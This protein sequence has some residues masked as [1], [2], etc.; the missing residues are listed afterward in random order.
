[1]LVV[2]VPSTGHPWVLLISVPSTGCPWV[3]V[4]SVTS[5]GH[6]C[7]LAASNAVSHPSCAALLLSFPWEEHLCPQPVSPSRLWICRILAWCWKSTELM[8]P[9]RFQLGLLE[10]IPG[11]MPVPG[12]FSQAPGA[13]PPVSWSVEGPGE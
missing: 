13:L 12:C 5:S 7:P 2:S 1:M 4:F 3:L 8:H 6:P 9:P 10:A 11:A